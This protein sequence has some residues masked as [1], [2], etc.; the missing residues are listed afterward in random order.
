MADPPSASLGTRFRRLETDYR[1]QRDFLN[2]ISHEIRAPLAVIRGYS[3]MLLAGDLG[4]LPPLARR[5]M[6]IVLAKAEQLD[7]LSETLLEATRAEGDKILYRIEPVALADLA[8]EVAEAFRAQPG[9]GSREVRVRGRSRLAL[10]DRSKLESVIHNLVSNA[11]KYSPP[12]SA[13]DILVR[14]RPGHVEITVSDRGPG[15]P[16]SMRPR[17]FRRFERLPQANRGSVAGIGL[18]LYISRVYVEGMGGEIWAGGRRGG[19]ASFH[20]ALTVAD[21]PALVILL[22]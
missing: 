7:D 16:A 10:A 2:F 22:K 19:G 15:I 4:P 8:R 11:A 3:Q 14:D 1:D 21:E 18:G 20:T 12:E 17:L 6:A 5:P 13:I 9:F